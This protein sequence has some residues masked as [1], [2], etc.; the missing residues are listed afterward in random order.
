MES[1]GSSASRNLDE[2]TK[3]DSEMFKQ[4]NPS[5]EEQKP[6]MDDENF[7]PMQDLPP[8]PGKENSP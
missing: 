4:R 3:N 7:F 6:L 1:R 8:P 5:R 2:N